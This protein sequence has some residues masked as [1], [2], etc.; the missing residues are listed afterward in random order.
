M[1]RS[2]SCSQHY[3]QQTETIQMSQVWQGVQSVWT[4]K[5]SHESPQSTRETNR[6]SVHCVTKVSVTAAVCSH[7]N[8]MYTATE[9]LMTV[10]TVG[11]G[12]K[13]AMNWSLYVYTHTGAKP[14]SCRH[15]S[16]CFRQTGHLKAHLLKSHNEGTWFTC[17]ICQKF[18]HSS[19]LK[20]HILRHEGLK[21]MWS[22]MFAVNVQWLSIQSGNC[23]VI[24]LNTQ[25][26]NSSAV[27]RV[28]NILSANLL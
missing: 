28:A 10:V 22:V 1:I 7:M 4:S 21:F 23:D 27:V 25:T 20:K 6:T 2:P 18:S 14:Y 3:P 9:D 5:H 16:D 13:V 17:H 15:C 19:S 24:S 11:N 8:V 12:L 26:S